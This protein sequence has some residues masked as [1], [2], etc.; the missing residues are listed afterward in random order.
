[1]LKP[2]KYNRAIYLYLYL[3]DHFILFASARV[4]CKFFCGHK[5]FKAIRDNFFQDLF[6]YSPMVHLF[7]EYV[8]LLLEKVCTVGTRP[9]LLR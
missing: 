3:R 8:S 9:L 5:L 1:M 4:Y 7:I 6:T 2:I